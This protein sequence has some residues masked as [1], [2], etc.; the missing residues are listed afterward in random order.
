MGRK[1]HIDI[2]PDGIHQKMLPL[3]VKIMMVRDGGHPG[4]RYNLRKGDAQG[5]VEGHGQGIFR[6]QQMN[7]KFV[8]E[9]VQAI[10]QFALNFIYFLMVFG[11]LLTLLNAYHVYGFYKTCKNC[12]TPFDWETCLGFQDVSNC[13]KKHGLKNILKSLN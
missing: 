7:V 12:D 8:D 1:C 2:L 13:F 5:K 10:F 3:P 9:I 6:N 11:L 4:F